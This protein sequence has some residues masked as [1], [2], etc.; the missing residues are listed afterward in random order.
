MQSN[1]RTVMASCRRV[2]MSLTPR[3]TCRFLAPV[4]TRRPLMRNQ[5]GTDR[6]AAAGDA[7]PR[8]ETAALQTSWLGEA[9][10]RG[11][12]RVATSYAVIAWLVVQ[13]GGT[14]FEPLGVPAWMFPALIVTAALGFPVA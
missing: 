2:P 7:A 3:R 6:A 4:C 14:I 9:R 13:I 10:R 8:N 12:L 5:D 11:V 1:A